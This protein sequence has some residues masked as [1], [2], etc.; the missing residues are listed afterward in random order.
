[1]KKVADFP[2]YEIV[3]LEQDIINW[4]ENAEF[5]MAIPYESRSHGTMYRL[6]YVSGVAAYVRKSN[7]ESPEQY[8]RDPVEAVER[9]K[10]KGEALYW[11][12]AS[13]V[14]LTAWDRPKELHVLG[15]A[16]QKIRFDGKILEVV[17]T[18]G[19]FYSLKEV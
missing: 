8:H 2:A 12:Q 9:A 14:S 15:G 7:A 10:A 6:Y 17:H 4:P 16:G 18:R 3:D 11:I 13:S 19:E 1:M 5:Q